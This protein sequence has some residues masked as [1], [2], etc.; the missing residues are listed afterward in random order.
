[1]GKKEDLVTFV[2]GGPTALAI[3]KIRDK[4][5]AKKAEEAAKKAKEAAEKEL[6]KDQAVWDALNDCYN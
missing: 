3:K 2:L 5:L 1:M 6:K 4:S